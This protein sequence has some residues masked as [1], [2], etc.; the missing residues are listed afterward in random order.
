MVH[1]PAWHDCHVHLLRQRVIPL[2]FQ[3]VASASI[4]SRI[5]AGRS[6]GVRGYEF[7]IDCG[8]QG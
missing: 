8:I 2:L 3:R 4:V 6:N 5:V 1:M 7:S